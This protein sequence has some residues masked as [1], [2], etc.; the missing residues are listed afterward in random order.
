MGFSI[1]VWARLALG[2]NWSGVVTLKENHQ[3]IQTGPYALVRHPIYTGLLTASLG[4][5]LT[6]NR[7]GAFLGLILIFMGFHMKMMVEER[8][9]MEQFG[10]A[11]TLYSQK[12]KKLIP[13]VY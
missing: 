9:M 12:V 5:A 1:S 8:F 3:L 6:L 7:G 2:G 11:Y 13:W 10:N 4:T